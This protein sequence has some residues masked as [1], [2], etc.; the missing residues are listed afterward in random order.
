M[1]K[2]FEHVKEQLESLYSD[3]ENPVLEVEKK[4][5]THC[6]YVDQQDAQAASKAWGELRD[7]LDTIVEK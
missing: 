2:D 4:L 5:E 3:L 6:I 7:K 1:R